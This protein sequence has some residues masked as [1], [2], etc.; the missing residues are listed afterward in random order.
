MTKNFP[1]EENYGLRSQIRRAAVSL[2][3]NRVEGCVREGEKDS[4]RFLDIAFGSLREVFYQLSL[5]SRLRYLP[6]SD[7]E[8]TRTLADETE[9][10]LGGLIRSI[11]NS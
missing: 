7:F 2:P 1:G 11:R 10:V 4:L 3:S 5:A 9:K 6:K 8:S